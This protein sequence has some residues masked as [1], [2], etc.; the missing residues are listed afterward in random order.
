LFIAHP[1]A[2]S[3]TRVSLRFAY[4]TNGLQSHRLADALAL[5]GEAGYHGVALTLD[6][7]HLDPLE[8]SPGEVQQVG[9]LLRQHR[10]GCVVETGARFLLDPHRKHWPALC[11]PDPLERMRRVD[12]LKRSVEVAAG[13]KA[14]LLNLA[15]GPLASGQEPD[16]AWLFL[17]ESVRE[18]LAH[19]QEQGVIV[20]VEPEPGHLVATLADFERLSSEVGGDLPLCLDVS[21][22]SVEAD[23]GTAAEAIVRHADRLALVHL[24]DAPLGRHEHLPL[25]EG[26]LDL[27][28][29]VGAL[30]QVGFEGLCAVELSRHSH[31]AHQLV[32]ETLAKLHALSR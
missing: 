19:A 20:S 17:V 5:L 11:E 15:S 13:L 29:I 22:V 6:H 25:G 28:G 18:V 14:E 12:L 9:R 3:I 1:A 10:L 24:E 26:E 30:E 2:G 32:P 4:N 27:P 8:A 21:H 16:T 31:A 23:E 7:M